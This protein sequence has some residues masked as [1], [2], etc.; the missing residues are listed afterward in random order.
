M[1]H[2]HEYETHEHE[3]K[4]C[5]KWFKK[6][7]LQFLSTYL[8][9]LLALCTFFAFHKPK[10]PPHMHHKMIYQYNDKNVSKEEFDAK[11]KDMEKIQK[12]YFK[13]FDKMRKEQAREMDKVR[14]YIDKEFERKD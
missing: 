10:M 3:H 14:N 12:E 6:F 11:N 8:G 9:V 5:C 13:E 7:L 2:E 1:T 4:S